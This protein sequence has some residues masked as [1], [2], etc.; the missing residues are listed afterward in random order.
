MRNL[1]FTKLFLGDAYTATKEIDQAAIVIGEA[2]A[3]AVQNRSA[4]LRERLRSAIE[5]LSPW[6]RSAAVRQLHER[7][8]TYHLS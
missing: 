4:R 1:A 6:R 8:R 3:L 2:A 5:R 7:L